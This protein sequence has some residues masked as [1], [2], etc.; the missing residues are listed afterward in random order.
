MRPRDCSGPIGAGNHKK[1]T[2]AYAGIGE[3]TFY[4]GLE[5]GEK[6]RNGNGYRQFWQSVENADAAAEVRNIAIIE[7]AAQNSWLARSEKARNGSRYL[8]FLESLEKGRSG[9][10]PLP[11]STGSYRGAS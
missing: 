5:L 9:R 1:V 6:A 3:R 10:L 8:E 7:A 2:A 4:R 11:F